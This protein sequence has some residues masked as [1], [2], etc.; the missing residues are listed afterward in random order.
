MN[1]DRV[2]GRLHRLCIFI[3]AA[4][5]AEFVIATTGV[6]IGN[7]PP[8]TD[9]ASYYLAGA[10]TRDHLSPY[11]RDA[12]AA[13]GHALGFAPIAA[14]APAARIPAPPAPSWNSAAST[15]GAASAT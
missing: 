2:T 3:V 6:Q 11:D 1:T 10:Q 7:L 14:A 12:I 9:F 15:P 8:S 5:G 4:A 13:R